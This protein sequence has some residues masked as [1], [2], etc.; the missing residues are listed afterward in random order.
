MIHM[1]PETQK[2]IEDT[3]QQIKKLKAADNCPCCGYPAC[4]HTHPVGGAAKR[5]EH[6]TDE[7][8]SKDQQLLK[9]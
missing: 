6:L 5:L 8:F 3:E 2:W 7:G 9:G 4:G 1:T